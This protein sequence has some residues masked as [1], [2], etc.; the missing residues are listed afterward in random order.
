MKSFIFCKKVVQPYTIRGWTFFTF[1][2]SVFS[3]KKTQIFLTELIHGQKYS[4]LALTN[5]KAFVLY[6]HFEPEATSFPE[7]GPH[8]NVLD[9]VATIRN[10]KFDADIIVREHPVMGFLGENGH[11][12]RSSIA[13]SVDFYKQLINLDCH[14]VD[15]EFVLGKFH[16]PVT[17]T[18]SIALERSLRG[19]K[20]IV[21][22]YPWFRGVPGTYTLEEFISQSSFDNT[23][24]E[25][26]AQS[27]HLFVSNILNFN[28]LFNYDVINF[29]SI[30][31]KTDSEKM[32][33][34]SEQKKLLAKLLDLKN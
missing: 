19:E 20:T 13:R 11:F 30:R 24:D 29:Y 32:E 9:L 26:I 4:N 18:G 8:Y 1:I 28:T 21:L 16:V 5:K 3:Y 22:G 12:A 10:C 31:N 27:A 25:K 6:L 15:S 33:F 7:G 14:F 17:L 23:R 34:W 2:N